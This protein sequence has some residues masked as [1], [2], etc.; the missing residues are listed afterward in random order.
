MVTVC[1]RADREALYIGHNSLHAR[2]HFVHTHGTLSITTYRRAYFVFEQ[3]TAVNQSFTGSC[4][5]DIADSG[6]LL[7]V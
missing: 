3:K 2:R 1:D 7:C 6:N 4:T 5:L